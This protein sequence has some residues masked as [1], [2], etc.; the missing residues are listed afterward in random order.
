MVKCKKCGETNETN[1][2]GYNKSRCKTCIC[3]AVKER[4]ELKKKDPSFVA[5]INKH[6]RERYNLKRKDPDFKLKKQKSWRKATLVQYKKLR[7]TT[8]GIERMRKWSATARKKPSYLKKRRENHKKRSKNDVKYVLVRRLRSRLRHALRAKGIKKTNAT[9][10]L[11]GCSPNEL[12]EHIENQ[13]SKNPGM[14][15]NNKHMWHIDHI[16]P[17]NSFDITDVE[18][19]KKCFHYTNLQPLW[20]MDNLLKSDKIIQKIS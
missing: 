13:F 18:Q 12:R 11:C 15:W 17:I 5:K 3:A 4:Y 6:S 9:M 10:D 16:L 20:A 19:Q 2:Y 7:S 8:R 14:S 1:F